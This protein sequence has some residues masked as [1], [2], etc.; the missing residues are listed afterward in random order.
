MG[1]INKPTAPPIEE[2]KEAGEEDDADGELDAGFTVRRWNLV[3]KHLEGPEPEFLA[4]RRKGLPSFY[5]G[6]MGPGGTTSGQMR[7]TKIRK[8]DSEGNVSIWDVLVPEGQ[9]VEGEILEEETLMTEAP[10]PGTVVEGVGVVNSEGVVIAGDQMLSTPPRR[11]PPPPKRKGK[12]VAKGKR[13][14]VGFVS[15]SKGGPPPKRPNGHL[16]VSSIS[17]SSSGAYAMK[18]VNV[19]DTAVVETASN[20]NGGGDTPMQDGEEGGEEGS[21]DDEDG[22]EGEEN[23]REEGEVSPSPSFSKSPS[24]TPAANT[25]GPDGDRNQ[26][27]PTIA[28]GPQLAAAAA[29]AAAATVPPPDRD[30]S[31]SPDLPLAAATQ[32]HQ[33]HQQ[34]Q[35]QQQQ[36]QTLLHAPLIRI[37]PAQESVISMPAPETIAEIPTPQHLSIAE[38]PPPDPASA[39]AQLPIDHDLLNGL[40]APTSLSPISVPQP[41]PPTFPSPLSVLQSQTRPPNQEIEEEQLQ[42]QQPQEQQQQQQQQPQQ[43]QQKQHQEQKQSEPEEAPEQRPEAQPQPQ[44]QA[45]NDIPTVNFPDGEE[46]LLGS[47]ERSLERRG[48]GESAAAAAATTNTTIVTTST[49]T[50]TTTTTTG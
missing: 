27:I 1:R 32:Q 15:I 34:Q 7:K 49:T 29:A 45:E 10:A 36:Q 12:G 14:R 2:E 47:L 37:E 30:M 33:Q 40:A 50:T 17:S 5:T 42:A 9:I 20:D 41:Q 24:K 26:D 4:K 44:P 48:N 18:P 22:E 43:Q 25:S 16:A 38:P 6:T 39:N 8:V 21:E 23:D 19:S 35:Q 11:R 46:D 3:P 13:K 31:S 28:L